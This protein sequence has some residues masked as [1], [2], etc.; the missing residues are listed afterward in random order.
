MSTI[1]TKDGT[2]ISH[3]DWGTDQPVLFSH[4]YPLTA[5][6]FVEGKEIRAAVQRSQSSADHISVQHIEHNH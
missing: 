2:A 5:A 3:E 6:P 1:T 4:R